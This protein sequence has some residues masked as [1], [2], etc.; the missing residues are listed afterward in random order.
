MADDYAHAEMRKSPALDGIVERNSDGK[1]VRYPIILTAREKIIAQKVA[2]AV[3]QQICGFDLLRANGMSYVIDVN[4]FSFVKSSQKYYDDCGHIL[5]VLITRQLNP[6]FYVPSELRPGPDVYT[7]L[8][9]TTYG[10]NMELRCVIGIIRHGDRTPKQKMKLEVGHQK[11]HDLFKKYARGVTGLTRDIKLKRPK[12]LQEALDIVL[13]ILEE[14]NS[15]RLD[16]SN[17][18]ARKPL[19]EKLR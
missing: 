6:K 1:E 15:G 18:V 11:F 13:F 7:P 8:Q 10:T 9:P 3:R 16:D 2:K 14:I 4:G 17:L 19:L 5:S 12:Q